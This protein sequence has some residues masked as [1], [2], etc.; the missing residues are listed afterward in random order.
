ML[1]LDDSKLHL[2]RA[3]T[4]KKVDNQRANVKNLGALMARCGAQV[5]AMDEVLAQT[6]TCLRSQ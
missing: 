4:F 5:K 3:I 1:A 2:E 6:K